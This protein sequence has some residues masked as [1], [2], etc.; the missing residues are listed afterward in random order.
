MIKSILID[1]EVH[2][3]DTLN[4][5]LSQYCPAVQVMERCTSARQGLDAFARHQPSL[6]FLDIEMPV[7]NGFEFLEQFK[8]IS[9]A[10]IFTTSYRSEEHTSELQSPCNLVCRLLL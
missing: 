9:F 2:C 6:I 10:I 7:M 5:L 8:E 1:D 3:L 4:I